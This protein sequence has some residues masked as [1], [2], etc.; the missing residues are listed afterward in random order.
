[1][2]RVYMR[3][4]VL[5]YLKNMSVLRVLQVVGGLD[6]GG[7]ESLLCSIMRNLDRNRVQFDFLKHNP[8]CGFYEKEITDAQ[9]KI[10]TAPAPHRS[11]FL[12]YIL[13]LRNFFREHGEYHIVH[14]HYPL[15]ASVYLGLARIY[16]R[17]TIAHAHLAAPF[18][19]IESVPVRTGRAL[20]QF[21]LAHIA[22]YRMACSAGAA[23]YIFGRRTAV[24]RDYIFLPNAR[25]T[26]VFAYN[27]GK[28][29]EMRKKLGL[30]GMFVTGH[31][32]RFE[33]QKN[34][35]FLVNV[36]CEI[37]K[38][39]PESRLLLMGDGPLKEETEKLTAEKGLSGKVIFTG[40]VPDPQNYYQ[41]MDLFVLPSLSE[42]L[43]LTMAEAQIS[44][45]PCLMAA[46]LP[47]EADL[48]CG[49]VST[50]GLGQPYSEWA[51]AALGKRGIKRYDRRD[52]AVKKGFDI[53]AVS[54]ELQKFYLSLE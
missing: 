1:M 33:K 43:P 49:L 13:W 6:V 31:A 28:R 10:Y 37:N 40:N 26:S 29:R 52:Y 17:R 2:G 5:P 27:A 51:E 45:L 3:P 30:E 38:R 44:G 54:A 50:V 4:G 16:G 21:P 23:E 19:P 14:G 20:L 8:A 39:C 9:G 25:D 35:A 41:A 47:R 34:H 12:K 48:G 42:G 32:G 11:G 24:N 18:S 36:F 15:Y 53:T 7:I 46:H 22:E